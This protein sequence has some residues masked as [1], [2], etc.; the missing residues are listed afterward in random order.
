LLGLVL[1]ASCVAAFKVPAARPAIVWRATMVRTLTQDEKDQ[2]DAVCQ[3]VLEFAAENESVGSINQCAVIVQGKTW[4]RIKGALRALREFKNALPAGHRLRAAYEA[5]VAR[6]TSSESYAARARLGNAHGKNV[7]SVADIREARVTYAARPLPTLE[8]SGERLRVEF[9]R[10]VPATAATPQKQ[11]EGLEE[12]ACNEAFLTTEK[13]FELAVALEETVGSINVAEKGFCWVT[14]KFVRYAADL[15]DAEHAKNVR[16]IEFEGWLQEHYEDEMSKMAEPRRAAGRAA[17]KA[18]HADRFDAH[19]GGYAVLE[20]PVALTMAP[21]SFVSSD[22]TIYR[23]DKRDTLTGLKAIADAVEAE[24]KI[25]IDSRVICMPRRK[26]AL[27]GR[28]RPTA[29]SKGSDQCSI[30]ERSAP[31]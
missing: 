3:E 21:G 5:V 8:D 19:G 10:A 9:E 28:L 30:K 7:P 26:S 24:Q 18:M 20:A 25:R 31:D 27:Y 2:R 15:A 16:A 6:A 29:L 23:R 4:L 17:S 12:C 14:D 22:R 11:L 13:S 1:T